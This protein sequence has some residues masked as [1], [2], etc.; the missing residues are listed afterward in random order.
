MYKWVFC[1]LPVDDSPFQGDLGEQFHAAP[2]AGSS[3]IFQAHAANTT[4]H[5]VLYF[6]SGPC[7]K[8]PI[9]RQKRPI[10]SHKRH[11]N[12]NNTP[13]RPVHIHLHIHHTD[14]VAIFFRHMPQIPR[15]TQ[16]CE[17][18]MS[19]KTHIYTKNTYV[20]A[21]QTHPS[22]KD[23][24]VYTQ[25]RPISA[26]KTP[27]YAQKRPIHTQKTPM[28]KP[29]RPIH[30]HKTPMYRPKRPIHAQKTPLYRPTRPNHTQ[31]TRLERQ[32]FSRHMLQTQCLPHCC[33]HL[34]SYISYV[35]ASFA[36]SEI[37]LPNLRYD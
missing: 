16:C 25:N 30:T 33:A 23:N 1:D 4:P 15:L 12:L 19:K 27:I 35:S 37:R 17:Q 8:R 13:K 26:Q 24:F 32:Y 9:Y 34:C 11:T 29:K 31:K 21:N 14:P 7:Q 2:V 10:D 20:Y 6:F 5:P 28:Y 22:S 36:K 18:N 3:H